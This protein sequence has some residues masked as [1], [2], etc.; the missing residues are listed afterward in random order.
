MDVDVLAELSYLLDASNKTA[1]LSA[2]KVASGFLDAQV[3]IVYINGLDPFTH[4]QQKEQRWVREH[5]M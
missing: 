4:V 5:V 2:M 1:F 3:R